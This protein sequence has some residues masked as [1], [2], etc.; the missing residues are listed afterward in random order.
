M[1]AYVTTQA[2]DL[3]G[4]SPPWQDLALC[5]QTDPQAFF[6]EQ[7]GSTRSAKRICGR[8]EVKAECLDYALAH[9]ER[10]GIWGGLTDRERQKL[11]TRAA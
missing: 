1:T 7:G 10:H 5:S 6:P 3:L 11:K 9:D 4:D 2:V 8:C